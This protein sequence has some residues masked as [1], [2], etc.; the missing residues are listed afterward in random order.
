MDRCRNHLA[1]L[2][3]SLTSSKIPNLAL[4]FRRYPSDFQRCNYFRFW[5]PCRYFRLSVAVVLSC[6]NYFPLLRGLIPQICSWYFNCIFHRFRDISISGFGRRF[7]LSVIIESPKYTSREF[8]MVECRRFVVGILMVYVTVSEISVLP[9]SWLPSW[10]SSTPRR[11]TKPEVP[12][13]ESFTAK[14]VGVAVGILSLYALEHEICLG[15]KCRKT[16]K[17]A[18]NDCGRVLLSRA[19]SLKT[20]AK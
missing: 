3:S 2:L 5:R 1:N 8:A 13:P 10:I 4:E 15:T 12:L 14:N 20:V 16:S 18:R 11:P 9:V 19:Q 6:R 17:S 7:R